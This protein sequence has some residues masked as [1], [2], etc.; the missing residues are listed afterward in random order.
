MFKSIS[1]ITE[2]IQTYE[3]ENQTII[4]KHIN[5]FVWKTYI[6][7]YHIEQLKETFTHVFKAS[8]E[9]EYIEIVK[10]IFGHFSESDKCVKFKIAVFNAEA[11]LIAF[12]QSLH[13]LGDICAHIIVYS[14]HELKNAFAKKRIG[15][16]ELANY[17]KKNVPQEELLKSINKLLDSQEYKYLEGYVNITKHSSLVST[18]YTV[19]F[20]TNETPKHY[21]KI[22]D[23]K[24]KK[25]H[26]KSI[27]STE[28]MEDYFDSLKKLYKEIF[29]ELVD[30]IVKNYIEKPAPNNG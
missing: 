19:S 27:S 24:Y 16:K 17:F 10:A 30:N 2:I 9:K 26:F 28:L 12:A 22:E 8:K 18:R 21:F 20:E 25:E 29:T 3:E 6:A 15:I 4:R 11:N 13:S 5:S 1:K 7:N 14:N 23:F